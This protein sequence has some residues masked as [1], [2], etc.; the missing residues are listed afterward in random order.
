MK[1]LIKLIILVIVSFVAASLLYVSQDF[2]LSSEITDKVTE[3]LSKNYKKFA[4]VSCSTPLVYTLG[5]IDPR[6]ALSN[7]EIISLLSEA[8]DV[9]ESESGKDLFVFK[10]SAED[11]VVINFIFDER[12][13]QIFASRTS[14]SLLENK[15]DTY[16]EIVGV[17]DKLSDKYKESLL[18][19]NNNVSIYE[20][21]RPVF[22]AKT[23]A[24]G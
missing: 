16:N 15:W 1:W 23:S 22:E 6:F 9:W 13:A 17:H 2:E 4:R 18:K 11:A 14:E 21:E 19:Y 3:Q 10:E 24:N 20:N 12:Q 8:E 7:E 5:D